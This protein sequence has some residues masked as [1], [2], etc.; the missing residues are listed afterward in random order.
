M[1]L[2]PRSRPVRFA[3]VGLVLAA[4]AAVIAT[5]C[6]SEDVDSPDISIDGGSDISV[7]D[8]EVTDTTA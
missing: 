6:S 5:G 4:F 2:A 3:L 7:T 1:K 8:D